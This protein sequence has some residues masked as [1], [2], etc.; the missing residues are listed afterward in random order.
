MYFF[1]FLSFPAEQL[2]LALDCVQRQKMPV[3]YLAEIAV[4][5]KRD[6]TDAAKSQ[7]SDFY[8]HV[9]ML[10]STTLL[11]P[12]SHTLANSNA[13]NTTAINNVTAALKSIDK[14][15]K[16]N[17][18]CIFY[19][20][21]Y[22]EINHFSDLYSFLSLQLHQQNLSDFMKVFNAQILLQKQKNEAQKNHIN[23]LMRRITTLTQTESV[24]MNSIESLIELSTSLQSTVEK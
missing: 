24:N 21:R 9:P 4:N 20:Q 16:E 7:P 15:N 11:S 3:K 22:A 6:Q 12:T 14:A 17:R 13:L 18:V 19:T 1:F 10:A 8:S 23:D 2:Q 5:V